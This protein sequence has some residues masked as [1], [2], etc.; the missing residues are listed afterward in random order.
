MSNKR[1]YRGH[2]TEKG[3]KVPTFTYSL[4]AENMTDA[5]GR[6]KGTG[7]LAKLSLL[8]IEELEEPPTP[9]PEIRTSEEKLLAAI[10]GTDQSDYNMPEDYNRWKARE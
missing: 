6:L 4:L 8:K 10:F 3:E 5:R 1:L 2:F 9:P 7:A